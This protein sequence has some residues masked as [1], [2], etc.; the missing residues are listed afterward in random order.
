MLL[1]LEKVVVEFLVLRFERSELLKK[2]ILML[3]K[4]SVSQNLKESEIES[5]FF[6]F[7]KNLQFYKESIEH[8]D[9]TKL[10]I[11]SKL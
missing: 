1:V 11:Q 4:V 5:P 7:Q 6:L 9:Q 2:Q 3:E 10:K 8:Q